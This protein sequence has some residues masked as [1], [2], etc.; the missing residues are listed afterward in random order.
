M[1]K[2]NFLKNTN[3]NLVNEFASFINHY[4]FTVQQKLHT[5]LMM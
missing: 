4:N 2:V 3:L 5:I 1:K